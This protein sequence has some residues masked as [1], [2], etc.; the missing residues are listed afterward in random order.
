M[1]TQ[2]MS[3][4]PRDRLLLSPPF[5]YVGVDAIGHLNV[6]TRKTSGGSANSNR[7]ATGCSHVFSAARST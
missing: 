4:P 1:V 2:V 5:A 7:W 6:I 3:D